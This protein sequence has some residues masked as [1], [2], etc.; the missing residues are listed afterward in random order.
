M[1]ILKSEYF[2]SID[3]SGIKY[4]ENIFYDTGFYKNQ[5]LICRYRLF[6]NMQEWNFL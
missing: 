4:Q 1:S 2:K 5:N 6:W 3:V